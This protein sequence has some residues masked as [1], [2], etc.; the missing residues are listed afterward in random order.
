MYSLEFNVI[1]MLIIGYLF[2][3]IP[4]GYLYCKAHGVNIFEIGSG[5]PGSTNVGRILG[6]THGRIV[7]ALDILK[8]LLPILIAHYVI[9]QLNLARNGIGF[10]SVLVK[11]FSLN[12]QVLHKHSLRDPFVIFATGFGAI[13]GHNFPFTT[14]FRGGKGIACTVAVIAYFNVIFAVVLYLIHKAIGKL[15]GY[16]SVASILTLI[17]MF[18]SSLMLSIFK[19]YP[20]NF[21]YAYAVLPGIFCM[22]LL[23]IARHK[24]NIVRLENGTENKI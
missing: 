14:G 3:S 18:L 1:L 24:E 16:V 8:T 11:N 15:T 13:L 17:I 21:D 9:I 10:S 19:V 20:F 23:G 2:G 22:M 6:K 4:V 5:N 7:F 12:L